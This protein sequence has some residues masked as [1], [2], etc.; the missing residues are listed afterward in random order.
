MNSAG[1]GT[2]DRVW[3]EVDLRAIVHNCRALRGWVPP[4]TQIMAVV[5]ADAYGH[6]ARRVVGALERHCSIR[7]FG[8]ATLDEAE[9]VR[10]VSHQAR[11][12]V[13]SPVL[14]EHVER[15]VELDAT[16]VVS[17]HA[18][19][20]P[21]ERAATA[22][23]QVVP[24][25]VKVD[26]G[27]GRCGVLPAE[28]P[29]L[30]CGIAAH[31]HV[32]LEALMTHF[33]DA[34]GDPDLSADQV[35]LLLECRSQLASLGLSPMLHCA[36]SA[37]ALLYEQARLDMI[38]P[39]MA[40]YGLMPP[41]PASAPRPALKPALALKARVLLVRALDVGHPISYGST[42][43]LSRPSRVAVLGIGYADG[44]RR[45]LSN[46]GFVAIHGHRAPVIGRV[47]MDMT[48]V[49]VTDIP[50]VRA[51]DVA[52]V[53]GRDGPVEILAVDLARMIGATEHEITTG[54]SARVRRRWIGVC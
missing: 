48:M 50:N 16:P 49:D 51:G 6:G 24:I 39:G 34:E 5:K 2:T 52:T 43:V 17:D 18:L 33:P 32:R 29:A 45:E 7:W 3:A 13:L 11:I 44:Y 41:L 12:L 10:A 4:P 40:L 20:E 27:M 38:R 19:L 15:L 36:N 28:L 31:A 53:I 9:D 14:P 8:V 54:L 42:H 25:H 47:C 23:D 35:R 22:R 37:G 30:A 46:R 21:I 26:T 1:S